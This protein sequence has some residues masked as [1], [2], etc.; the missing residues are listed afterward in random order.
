MK[1]GKYPLVIFHDKIKRHAWARYM[2]GR[3]HTKN[4]NNLVSVVGATGSGKTYTAISICQIMSKLDGIPF[5]IDN[6][7]F[8]LTELMKLINSNKLQKGSKIVFD[9]PQISIGA[10]DFQSKANK[11]FNF[12][13]ST[14]RH[15]NL[16]LLFCTPF[17]KLLDRSTRKLFHMRFQTYKIIESK[18][19]CRIIPVYLE[20]SSRQEDPYL[21]KLRMKFFKN[22]QLVTL[23]RV[24]YWDIPKPSDDFI[25][26]YEK[27]KRKFTDTL[28]KNILKTLSDY[29][30][31]GKTMTK[32]D[33]DEK[34][35]LTSDEEMLVK[36]LANNGTNKM[37]SSFLN[38]SPSKIKQMR[39]KINALNIPFSKYESKYFFSPKIRNG[40]EM[41]KEKKELAKFLKEK[42]EKEEIEKFEKKKKKKT[43]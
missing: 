3:I 16:T 5:T 39:A 6:V 41:T 32:S 7:V 42:M 30:E 40:D 25:E 37:A 17:E 4:N 35:K 27:K 31:E 18:Q 14:F 34:Y 2:N 9:E 19:V 26:E 10:R 11:I 28:N 33:D 21:K 20:H 43:L 38:K 22:G 29:E 23:R 13:V 12:L 36:I 8:S 1:K 15:R 24:D